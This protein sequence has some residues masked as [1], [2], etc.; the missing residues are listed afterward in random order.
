MRSHV[1][2]ARE[3]EARQRSYLAAPLMEAA[4]PGV[5][6][7]A[8]RFRFTDPEGKEKPQPYAQIFVPDMRAYFQFQCP[9]RECT[10]G[11]FDLSTA[12]P[13]GLTHK[14][15]DKHGSLACG[16]QRKRPHGEI[17]RCGLQLEYEVMSPG[18]HAANG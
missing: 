7:L 6:E 12:V 5:T 11:G 16:G 2:D 10:G 15:G 17:S 18:A 14:N 8:V 9:L 3:R 1:L 4:F 13:R